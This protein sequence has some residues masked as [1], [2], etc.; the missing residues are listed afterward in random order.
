MSSSGFTLDGL[1]D[2]LSDRPPAPY[3]GARERS[4]AHP[5]GPGP[6]AATQAETLRA[7]SSCSPEL[8]GKTRAMTHR[9]AYGVARGAFDP[10][11]VLALTFTTSRR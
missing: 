1:T 5:G 11:S 4:D 2:K 10:H 8:H 6:G 7:R 9:I 3:G